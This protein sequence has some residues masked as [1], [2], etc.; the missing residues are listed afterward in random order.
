V[1]ALRGDRASRAKT[2]KYSY[3]VIPILRAPYGYFWLG[4]TLDLLYR[5]GNYTIEQVSLV[6]FQGV[7]TDEVK[8]PILRAEWDA[9]A[10]DGRSKHAQPHWHVYSSP[11]N[12]TIVLEYPKFSVETEVV[13]FSPEESTSL[14]GH[15]W[16]RGDRFH[17]AMA[18]KWHLDGV[19]AHQE[20]L[21]QEK[22][23]KWLEGCVGYIRAQLIYIF[24]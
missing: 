23:L 10:S 14:T 19:D 1:Y 7:A 11:L 21:E 24:Q 22:L 8:T 6:I 2:K 13:D 17:F 20:L 12:N 15:V 4:G 18:S 16:E 9:I 5:E 3:S